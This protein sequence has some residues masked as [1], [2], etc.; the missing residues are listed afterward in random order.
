VTVRPNALPALEALSASAGLPTK[1]IGRVGGPRIRIAVDRRVLID[2]GI[3][4][5]EYIWATAIERFFERPRAI[6]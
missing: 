1:V 2:E 5:V 4:D 6:A 3:A